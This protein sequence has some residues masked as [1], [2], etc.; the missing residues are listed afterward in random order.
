MG[1]LET[2]DHAFEEMLSRSPLWRSLLA[3]DKESFLSPIVREFNSEPPTLYASL[4]VPSPEL[5][6]AT[7]WRGGASYLNGLEPEWWGEEQRAVAAIV[8]PQPRP[9]WRQDD[10]FSNFLADLVLR[11]ASVITFSSQS[12]DQ[13]RVRCSLYERNPATGHSTMRSLIELQ[14]TRDALCGVDVDAA[15]PVSCLEYLGVRLARPWYSGNLDVV[16]TPSSSDGALSELDLAELSGADFEAFVAALLGRMGFRVEQTQASWDGGIDSI[17]VDAR[18]IIGG[19]V[20]VQVKRY[21]NAVDASAVR[22]LYGTVLSKGANKGVIITTG[23]FGPT[24]RDFATG[25]P[26]ELID[27]DALHTLLR[28]IDPTNK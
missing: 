8:A 10:A 18:P 13:T 7:F 1:T 25:K 17:A 24:S 3:L 21:K 20:L 23:T 6:H 9:I 11:A 4:T 19:T 22:D 14:T 27:G 15:N 16:S 5:L 26:I 2:F 12:L 28:E